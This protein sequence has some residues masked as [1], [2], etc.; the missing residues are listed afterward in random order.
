[1]FA[2]NGWQ[3]VAWFNFNQL[4][5][6]FFINFCVCHHIS[7]YF[8]RISRSP[9]STSFCVVVSYLTYS[10]LAQM[11]LSIARPAPWGGCSVCCLN[12]QWLKGMYHLH[13]SEFKNNLNFKVQL[14]ELFEIIS[15]NLLC[16]LM[17]V[18]R[19]WSEPSK[20]KQKHAMPWRTALTPTFLG[21]VTIPLIRKYHHHIINVLPAY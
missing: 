3:P 17:A 7:I 13:L 10:M 11:L 16:N 1:M 21:Y 19:Q 4:Y 12:V 6:L 9:Y 8:M 20:C 14:K 2:T 18:G 5:S 15:N